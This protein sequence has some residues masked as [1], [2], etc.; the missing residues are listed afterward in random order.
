MEWLPASSSHHSILSLLHCP[1]LLSDTEP[2]LALFEK[3]AQLRQIVL[4]GLKR[5]R[6][7]IVPSEQ[8]R[9][10]VLSLVYK[11][12]EARSRRAISRVDLNLIASLGVF[13]SNDAD[14]WQHLFAFVMNMNGHEIM[15]PSTH[16]ERPREIDDADAG[17]G[18]AHLSAP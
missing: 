15:S 12:A 14:I 2:A 5:D 8:A 10:F 7:D 6:V 11:I 16:G 3:R 4:A 17:E 1:A 13:Q 9:K 18:A